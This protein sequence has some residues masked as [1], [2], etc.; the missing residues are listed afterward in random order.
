MD[1]GSNCPVFPIQQSVIVH[2][3]LAH[4]WPL[5][6]GALSA[7]LP[8]TAA[9]RVNLQAGPSPPQALGNTQKEISITWQT[10][11]KLQINGQ[12]SQSE[13]TK[14]SSGNRIRACININ[15]PY[16][17][18]Y[19]QKNKS[20]FVPPE[21]TRWLFPKRRQDQSFVRP[22]SLI[23]LLILGDVGLCGPTLTTLAAPRSAVA[24]VLMALTAT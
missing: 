6:P 1:A 11:L 21:K 23:P 10:Q 5:C 8:Y 14:Q 22:S 9:S 2:E 7:A 17:Y 16:T 13:R 3:L 19:H 20:S 4:V 18:T 15:L 24:A 12:T